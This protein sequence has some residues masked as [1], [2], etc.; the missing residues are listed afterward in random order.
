[1]S[2]NRR[3]FHPFGVPT[4]QDPAPSQ[5]AL[6]ALSAEVMGGKGLGLI[7]MAALGIPIPMGFVLPTTWTSEVGSRM[8]SNRDY[9]LV[10]AGIKDLERRAGCDLGDPKKS[11]LVSV[12]SGAA[13]SM[14]GMLD[15]VLNLGM[16]REVA[17][18]VDIRNPGFGTELLTRFRTQYL[19]VVGS[20]PSQNPRDQLV[21]AIKSVIASVHSERALTF[22]KQQNLPANMATAVIVQVMAFGNR[23]ANSG[24]GVA[25]SRNPIDG[26]KGLYG[27]FLLRAQG[28]DIVGGTQITEPLD[29]M[30]QRWPEVGKD[31]ERVASQLEYLYRD[32][33]DIEFT[34][35]RSNLWILQA[36]V[37]MRSPRA[38]LQIAVDLANDP[39]FDVTRAEAVQRCSSILESGQVQELVIADGQNPDDPDA[40]FIEAESRI[41]GQ[42]LAASPGVGRGILTTSLE[43]A[44]DLA[45]AGEDVVLARRETSPHDIAGMAA[46]KAIVTTRGGLVSHAAI[47]AR[48]WKIPAVVGIEDWKIESDRIIDS[49]TEEELLSG[50]EVTVDGSTGLVYRGHL[51]SKPTSFVSVSI[52]RGWKTALFISDEPEPTPADTDTST[53]TN[54]GTNTGSDV[55]VVQH[56]SVTT[57]LGVGARGSSQDE[58]GVGVA[59]KTDSTHSG[60]RGSA[61]IGADGNVGDSGDGG[62]GGD[63]GSGGGVGADGRGYAGAYS[64]LEQGSTIDGAEAGPVYKALDLNEFETSVAR[65]ICL[66]GDTD[67][68]T[69]D[70]TLC[71]NPL[72]QRTS[73]VSGT[74]IIN[75]AILTLK[76]QG[77]VEQIG[78]NYRATQ[79]AKDEIA[80]IYSLESR[81]AQNRVTLALEQFVPLDLEFKQVMNMWQTREFHGQQILNDHSDIAYDRSVIR[82]IRLEIH[83][84]ALEVIAV[85][86]TAIARLDRYRYRLS[87]ALI[88]AETGN[89]SMV[90]SP[91][92]DSY[93]TVWFELH[94][95]LLR[96]TDQRRH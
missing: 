36:R 54:T 22:R 60:E 58:T 39:D 65:T 52:L 87:R 9:E 51:A 25:F 62:D 19:S 17:R 30:C 28:E 13:V 12:R 44:I 95:E 4:A 78:E 48:E 2:A 27:D 57:D 37:G 41:I 88:Q 56:Q 20:E 46:A 33:V 85:A 24:T 69:L 11:L 74:S 73:A 67:I 68:E 49:S 63:G 47:V 71:E 32:M 45:A 64:P 16:T 94:E 50:S 40:E 77:L 29:V 6:N 15:T 90:A 5:E 7:R 84:P 38:A 66:K 35:D 96:L 83:P 72:S 86:A 59:A 89:D 3:L 53:E 26:S 61:D 42:G 91:L 93:H 23:D 55:G 21:Q 80:K 92:F 1:M 34:V 76:E 81:Q 43:E 31:L 10:E 82:R 14:P 75:A 18:A 8:W 70:F 79:L